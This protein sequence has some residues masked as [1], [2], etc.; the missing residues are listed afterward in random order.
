M[1][2][3]QSHSI[4]Q[5]H[6]RCG[7]FRATSAT[8]RDLV[9]LAYQLPNGHLRL[10]SQISGGPSWINSDRF[11]IVAK[12]DGNRAGL[13]A[14][15]PAGAVRA[16]DVDA[17]DQFRLMVRQLL[18]DRFQLTVHNEMRQQPVYALEVARR[19]GKPGPQLH[20][21]DIDCAAQYENGRRPA[22][23]EPGQAAC[24][25]FTRLGPG[26]M[27]GH[28][29][30]MSMLA[31]SFPES[32]GRIVVDRTGLGG[33]F[34]LDLTWTPDQM[35]QRGEPFP[36]HYRPV[37]VRRSSPPCRNS[38]GSSWTPKEAR[39]TSSSSIVRN[40]P[41]RISGAL[42]DSSFNAFHDFEHAGWQKAAEY[43]ADTFGTLT[44]RTT[45][46][47]LESAGVRRGRVCS[48]WRAARGMWRAR[49]RR[50]APGSS[51]SISRR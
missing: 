3:R 22:P 18:A 2:G 1:S 46:P 23:P 20:K 7:Q 9:T 40:T 19:D 28:A 41:D 29:V 11:D 47:L 44:A 12:A 14:N 25:G 34:D 4:T 32:V 38:S 8:L 51:D 21:V 31:T 48:T 6:G 10:D 43:Y 45:D 33:V 49:R 36:M 35:P 37:T 24:G 26:H 27:T 16:G 39:S 50:E 17:V 30:T 42:A 15:R 5:C 13:V